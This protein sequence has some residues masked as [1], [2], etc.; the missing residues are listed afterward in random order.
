MSWPS[1]DRTVLN[2]QNNLISFHIKTKG[3]KPLNGGQKVVKFNWR[4]PPEI[5]SLSNIP[6]VTLTERVIY[7]C[8]ATA[9]G[10]ITRARQARGMH[11][12]VGANHSKNNRPLI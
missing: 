5:K 8:G 6:S 10:R 7:L 4:Q 1:Q 12:K 11:I 3:K 9:F 2:K